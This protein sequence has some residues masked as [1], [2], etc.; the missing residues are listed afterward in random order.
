MGQKEGVRNKEG[1]PTAK[2]QT[3]VFEVCGPKTCC[4]DVGL[5]VF[6]SNSDNF[7]LFINELTEP[8]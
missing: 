1:S 8:M 6:G 3:I 7:G 2:R 5:L 4:K